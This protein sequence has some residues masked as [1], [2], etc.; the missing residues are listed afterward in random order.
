MSSEYH[1]EYYQKN[2]VKLLNRSKKRAASATPEEVL[3]RR[4]YMREYHAK[5]KE[6]H[7]EYGRNYY[8][9]NRDKAYAANLMKEYGL[10]LDDYNQMLE[11]QNGVCKICH[12]TCTH[13]QR[14]EAGTLCVDHCHTTGKVRG[15]L[16]NKCNT[17]LG[18][19]NDDLQTVKRMVDYLE[20]SLT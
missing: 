7:N 9:N 19:L 13:P 1:K 17:A 20:D 6:K 2:R 5:N 11:E 12:G 8:H 18:F 10:T 14:R 4:K 15:L 16:C 3:K